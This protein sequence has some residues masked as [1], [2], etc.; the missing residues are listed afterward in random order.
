[1]VALAGPPFVIFIGS[2]NNCS[3][4]MVELIVVNKIIGFSNGNTI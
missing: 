1:M 2:S 4:P 3:V